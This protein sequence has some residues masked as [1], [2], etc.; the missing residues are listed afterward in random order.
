MK[1]SPASPPREGDLPETILSFLLLITS[2][3]H[4]PSYKNLPCC[5]TLWSSPLLA[6]WDP[7][8][9]MNLL[10]KPI[11][12]S[13]LPGEILFFNKVI[14]QLLSEK[15]TKL[16]LLLDAVVYFLYG[17]FKVWSSKIK[18]GNKSTNFQIKAMRSRISSQTAFN[19]QVLRLSQQNNNP[20]SLP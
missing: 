2:L 19:H 12:S 10:I 16:H 5:T 13:N 14:S 9:F 17:T 11:R 18:H 8:Q 1:R 4:L 6:R 3:P 7:A 15:Y 20:F